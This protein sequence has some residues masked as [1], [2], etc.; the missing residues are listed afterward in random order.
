MC[1]RDRSYA[2]S[3]LRKTWRQ[4]IRSV[5]IANA[6]AVVLLSAIWLTPLLNAERIATNSQMA[7]FAESGDPAVLDIWALGQWGKAGAAAKAAL[8]VI[9]AKPGQEALAA[10]LAGDGLDATASPDSARADLIA[11]LPL[12]PK[13]ATARRDAFLAAAS[14]YDLQSWAQSCKTTM[15]DGAPGC[16]MVIADFFPDQPG[17][18]ALFA[19]YSAADYILSLIHI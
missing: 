14:L 6:L 10:V 15:P 9:A 5:N 11:V 3:A 4:D 13:A 7:R 16:V 1:I 18:E 12:Q 17:D 2:V 8:A 19:L